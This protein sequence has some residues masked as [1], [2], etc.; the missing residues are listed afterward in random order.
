MPGL[1][2]PQPGRYY[3]ID[4]EGPFVVA[5]IVSW[6]NVEQPLVRDRIAVPR[7]EAVAD[8]A[9][10]AA[11]EMWE[12]KNDAAHE[13]AQK[14]SGE[15]FRVATEAGFH[16]GLLLL[17]GYADDELTGLE[18]DGELEPDPTP[19]ERRED[20]RAARDF[21]RVPDELSNLDVR[22]IV[23]LGFRAADMTAETQQRGDHEA[24]IRWKAVAVALGALVN[25]E[26]VKPW[27]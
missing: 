6:V 17:A 5:E 2:N 14:R 23:H 25:P 1:D 18:A 20:L 19:M 13:L 15:A 26:E 10:R 4:P 21:L 8:A 12:A 24:A 16:A 3:V 7:E 22:A 9:W 11:V 27:F